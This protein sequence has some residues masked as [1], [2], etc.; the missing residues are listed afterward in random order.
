MESLATGEIVSHVGQRSDARLHALRGGARPLRAHEQGSVHRQGGAREAA[1]AGRAEPL[2]HLRGAR[3][4][5]CRSARQ[6]ALVRSRAAASSAARRRATT[7]TPCAR[8]W[9]WGTSSPSSQPS[10]S[11]IA[12]EI[13]GRAQARPRCSSILPTILRTRS[14]GPDRAMSRQR[15]SALA[16][17]CRG[18]SRASRLVAA[19]AQGRAASLPMTPSSSAAAATASAP[20]TT[21]RRSTVSAE[22]RRARE[23]AGSAAATPAATPPSSA[24]ITLFNESAALYDHAVKLW[25]DLSQAL[26]YNVMFSPR[27][28]MMLAHTVH[29]VQVSSAMCTPIAATA[30]TMSGSSR[31]QA[32]AFCPPLNIEDN[33]RYPVLGAALQRRGG[34][35]RHDA[36]AWGYARAA[37]ALG[38][39]IIENCEVTGIRRKDASGAVEALETTRGLIRGAQGGRVRGRP[40]QRDHGD[41]RACTCRSRAIRCRHWFPSPSSR[42]FPASSCR[43]PFT[44]TSASRTRANW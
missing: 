25:E 13:L 1:R 40:Y 5:R 42:F 38:V 8:A 19:V 16:L 21:W 4:H 6:R 34:T 2:H 28:V 10:G 29:D 18:L 17:L 24:P 27:G 12:I 20:R 22:H 33:I 15:F 7:G 31:Q 3:R 32:K 30:S 43:T 39:D 14:C 44:P 9:G 11:E 23:R 35:A 37:D 26:N 41:G 36:V